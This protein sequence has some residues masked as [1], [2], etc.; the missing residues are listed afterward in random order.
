[1]YYF[2]KICIPR[3]NVR[4][5]IKLAHDCPAAS[6]SSVFKAMARL[7][8]FYWA[9]KTKDIVAYCRGCNIGIRVEDGRQKPLGFPQPLEIPH[10][11]W[12]SVSI[13]S[14]ARLPFT[15]KRFDPIT[16]FVD[17]F[18]KRVHFISCHL[19][20]S[21]V[22]TANIFLHDISRLHSLSDSIFFDND[23][24][25][26]SKFWQTVMNRVKIRLKMSTS[27]RSQTDK[28]AEVMNRMLEN[29]I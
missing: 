9:N 16:I 15:M 25:F 12:G 19:S 24:K 14:I 6:H 27:H 10:R 5:A 3:N 26:T 17:R 28:A 22:N 4:G 13:E 1:M 29:Y 18:T 2:G 7:E 20:D 21:T 11:R 23:P 8:C